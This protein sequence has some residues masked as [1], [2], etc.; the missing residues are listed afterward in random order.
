MPLSGRSLKQ[1]SDYAF[2]DYVMENGLCEAFETRLAGP[3]HNL[4]RPRVSEDEVHT[5][6]TVPKF[7]FKA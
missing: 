7:V 3:N 5:C 6:F 1:H 2:M 4:V